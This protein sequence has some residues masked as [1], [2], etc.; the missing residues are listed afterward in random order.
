MSFAESLALFVI[1]CLLG[2]SVMPKYI[3]KMLLEEVHYLELL[4]AIIF[5]PI[6]L[7]SELIGMSKDL[8]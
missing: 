1:P 3:L 8:K 2:V 7:L 5:G 6:E 4:T